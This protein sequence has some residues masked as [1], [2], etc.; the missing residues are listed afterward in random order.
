MSIASHIDTLYRYIVLQCAQKS[1]VYEAPRVE[2]LQ[3]TH[4][5]VNLCHGLLFIQIQKNGASDTHLIDFKRAD[6]QIYGISGCLRRLSHPQ[7]QLR[8]LLQRPGLCRWMNLRQL[9]IVMLYWARLWYAIAQ[10]QLINNEAHM[11]YVQASGWTE[12]G[13]TEKNDKQIQI[14]SSVVF[15]IAAGHR[16]I[17]PPKRKAISLFWR[18]PGQKIYH[19]KKE[20][21]L[22]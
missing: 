3:L 18:S 5:Y 8:Q 16:T 6:I 4:E 13:S 17:T 7:V 21:V 22:H 19:A 10:N 15:G 14:N 9:S 2:Q 20:H 1:S 11:H 12:A